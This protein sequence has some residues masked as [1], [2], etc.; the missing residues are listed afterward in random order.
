MVARSNTKVELREITHAI[1]KIL[2][3]KMILE[4][5]KVMVKKPME[6]YCDNKVTINISHSLVHQDSTKPVEVDHHFFKEKIDEG[7]VC[8][9]YILTTK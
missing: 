4:E 7:V 1:C 9:T 8:I 3:L 6:V 5:L 2:W